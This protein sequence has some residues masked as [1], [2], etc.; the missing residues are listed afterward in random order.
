MKDVTIE[1]VR[2]KIEEMERE[3]IEPLRIIPVPEIEKPK[4]VE[5]KDE[6]KLT[7][8]QEHIKELLGPIATLVEQ[9]TGHKFKMM[10]I[11]A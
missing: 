3:R 1:P 5:I 6:G 2:K 4:V 7:A 9:K 10:E 11:L 8:M